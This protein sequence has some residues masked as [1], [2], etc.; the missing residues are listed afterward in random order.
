MQARP[1]KLEKCLLDKMI[2][3]LRFFFYDGTRLMEH[4]FTCLILENSKMLLLGITT[5]FRYSSPSNFLKKYTVIPSQTQIDENDDV[6]YPDRRRP[7]A[8]DS[9]ICLVFRITFL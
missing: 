9:L 7:K 5:V 6:G 2:W 8:S 4:V 1:H 3:N